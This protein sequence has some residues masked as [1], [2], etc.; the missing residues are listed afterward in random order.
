MRC[1]VPFTASFPSTRVNHGDGSV[2][3]PVGGR[4]ARHGRAT[5]M[6][7]LWCRWND[8]RP[9]SR[10]AAAP[11][12]RRRSAGQS[13]PAKEPYNIG[14]NEAAAA[15]INSSD[16][17]ENDAGEY[18]AA[19]LLCCRPLHVPRRR[20]LGAQRAL[21]SGVPQVCLRSNLLD[22][23]CPAAPHGCASQLCD[24]RARQPLRVR[25]QAR[26]SIDPPRWSSRP[27]CPMLHPS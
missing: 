11:S 26:R 15:E 25:S 16:L 10:S 8:E 9:T 7:E 5:R 12:R 14:T 2:Q 17:P 1:R 18:S 19:T 3:L 24:A 6:R 23:A 22:L 13:K 4:Q 21:T 27:T 20:C